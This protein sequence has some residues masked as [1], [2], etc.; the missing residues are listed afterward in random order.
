MAKEKNWII[1]EKPT[2]KNT[3]VICRLLVS[4]LVYIYGLYGLLVSLIRRM[5]GKVSVVRGE[6][7]MKINQ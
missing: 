5:R 2:N 7:R 4:N 3:F 1:T 6:I